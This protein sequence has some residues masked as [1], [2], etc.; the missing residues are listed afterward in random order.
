MLK[1]G[2]NVPSPIEEVVKKIRVAMAN[3]IRQWQQQQR[4]IPSVGFRVNSL[5][6]QSVFDEI[7]GLVSP[8]PDFKIGEEVSIKY[9][10]HLASRSGVEFTGFVLNSKTE[11]TTLEDLVTSK[12]GIKLEGWYEKIYL[13]IRSCYLLKLIIEL[14]IT[15]Q[16]LASLIPDDQ[17][18]QDIDAALAKLERELAITIE[19]AKNLF[20]ALRIGQP[21]ITITMDQLARDVA[22][23]IGELN[24]GEEYVLAAGGSSSS[25]V[26]GGGH[27]VYVAFRR[28]GK[29]VMIRIDNRGFGIDKPAFGHHREKGKVKP[30]LLAQVKDISFF[31]QMPKMLD[32]LRGIINSIRMPQ[33]ISLE[34]ILAQGVYN[35]GVL[36][37]KPF[38]SSRYAPDFIRRKEQMVGNCVVQSWEFGSLYRLSTVD[39]ATGN[40]LDKTLYKMQKQRE[41]YFAV[42]FDRYLKLLREKK[43]TAPTPV[44]P[45]IGQQ[46]G[47]ALRT[48]AIAC[49]DASR[50]LHTGSRVGRFHPGQQ[51]PFTRGE[52]AYL[53]EFREVLEGDF[54]GFEQM[55]NL[56]DKFSYQYSPEF[57]NIAFGLFERARC[58]LAG[59]LDTRAEELPQEVFFQILNMIEQCNQHIR[60]SNLLSHTSEQ[61][62]ASSSTEDRRHQ[63]SAPAP[64]TLEPIRPVNVHQR[65]A[66]PPSSDESDDEQY[67]SDSRPGRW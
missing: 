64:S 26:D 53:Q 32:Y 9:L 52:E 6:I 46:H 17:M 21:G 7:V 49:S 50:G 15:H 55:Q 39:G 31:S 66:T 38:S 40:I 12:Q 22:L 1:G 62:A 48:G 51:K 19:A 23:K 5:D 24:D 36:T 60:T 11:K 29:K 67:F 42:D 16:G 47:G 30:T 3:C 20:L 33:Q 35:R 18:P 2:Y 4:R 58:L 43:K 56:I 13:F 14:K 61:R 41:R 8:T 59:I 25:R 34:N 54:L 45:F 63:E 37:L 10:S 28:R 65:L 57:Y 27:A 44:S